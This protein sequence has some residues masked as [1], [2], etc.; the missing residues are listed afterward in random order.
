MYLQYLI[1]KKNH[2]KDTNHKTMGE[3]STDIYEEA[4]ESDSEP[5][6]TYFPFIKIENDGSV[7]IDG[8]PSNQDASQ[9]SIE[10]AEVLVLP[11]GGM[12]EQ[13]EAFEAS[14]HKYE[15]VIEE[16]SDETNSDTVTT[17]DTDISDTLLHDHNYEEAKKPE[18]AK[19][20]INFTY[21]IDPLDPRHNC[22]VQKVSLLKHKQRCAGSEIQIIS[23][24]EDDDK[25]ECD[26]EE[27]L[28]EYESIEA[29]CLDDEGISINDVED[30]A[31]G[32]M[33]DKRSPLELELYY[34]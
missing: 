27:L 14:D 13:L 7:L 12:V 1:I 11:F 9:M 10:S 4:G 26:Q 32:Y 8:Q 28:K 3:E 19:D 30:G 17:N 18:N 29:Q 23:T 22:Y 6:Y 34:M 33:D 2:H 24:T 15:H 5:M 21:I 20:D 31:F 16:I 25:A